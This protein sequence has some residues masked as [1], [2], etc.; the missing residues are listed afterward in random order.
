MNWVQRPALSTITQCINPFYSILTCTAFW[1]NTFRYRK[2]TNKIPNTCRTDLIVREFFFLL[3]ECPIAALTNYHKCSGL[4][5]H[6][7]MT[8]YFCGPDTRHGSHRA[9]IKVS[10]E[11]HPFLEALGRDLILCLFLLPHCLSLSP[12]PHFQIQQHQVSPHTAS[13]HL[14][15]RLLSSPLATCKEPC[16][17]PGP[18]HLT[19]LHSPSPHPTTPSLTP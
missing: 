17:Y 19:N 4:K 5:Q 12:F 13:C 1:L 3:Y 8:F 14:S 10:S 11:L 9:K 18:T 7:F 2:I 6:Q 16:D 15:G